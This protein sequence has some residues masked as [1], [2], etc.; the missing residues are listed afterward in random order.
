[1]MVVG[2]GVIVME[3][4]EEVDAWSARSPAVSGGEDVRAHRERGNRERGR[5][6]SE[7]ALAERLFYSQGL[8]GRGVGVE[9][10]YRTRGRGRQD[11]GEQAGGGTERLSRAQGGKGQGGGGWG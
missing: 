2:M 1:M 7:G 3:V 4:T 10:G 11:S 6:G 5:A 9:E 8:V